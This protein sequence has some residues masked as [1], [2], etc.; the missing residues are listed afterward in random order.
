MKKL[1]L[2]LVA[3]G[4]LAAEVKPSVSPKET[5]HKFMQ[6]TETLVRN[7]YSPEEGT[8]V[9]NKLLELWMKQK[10][11]IEAVRTNQASEIS[12]LLI[13]AGLPKADADSS[14]L[15]LTKNARSIFGVQMYLARKNIDPNDS[16]PIASNVWHIVTEHPVPSVSIP[17]NALTLVNTNLISERV[18]RTMFEH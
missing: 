11:D 2:V 12:P 9:A 15:E 5:S 4:A 13:K 10:E 8:N 16:G 17:T 6:F 3:L 7:G 14:A 1:L 18:L